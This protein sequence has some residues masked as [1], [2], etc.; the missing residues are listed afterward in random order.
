M[1]VS[2]AGKGGIVNQYGLRFLI[3]LTTLSLFFSPF[4]LIF[5]E[6]CRT[7]TENASILSSWDFFRLALDREI[8]K[9]R[10]VL[11][12]FKKLYNRTLVLLQRKTSKYNF[13]LL[14]NPADQPTGP[15]TPVD[16]KSTAEKEK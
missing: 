8:K 2:T 1:L 10:H 9:L 11:S 7:L 3:S 6:R 13:P 4:W 16:D 15:G 14:P 5:A 12:L